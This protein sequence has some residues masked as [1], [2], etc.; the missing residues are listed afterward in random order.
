VTTA[1]VVL[2]ALWL[3]VTSVALPSSWRVVIHLPGARPHP[4]RT[5]PREAI[6]HCG[7]VPCAAREGSQR[8]TR[9]FDRPRPVVCSFYGR[10]ASPA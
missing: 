5:L 2:L 1:I 8:R 3:S 10:A 9:E 6:R 4:E 7:G